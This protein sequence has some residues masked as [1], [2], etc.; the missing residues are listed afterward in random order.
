MHLHGSRHAAL[1]RGSD[2]GPAELA[3]ETGSGVLAELA[4]TCARRGLAIA[5]A[6]LGN[7]A[8]A[9]EAVQEAF[10]R[11]CEHIVDLRDRSRAHAWF[12][13]V[14]ATTC[15][16][17]LRRRKHGP[18]PFAWL[19]GDAGD[20]AAT[21]AEQAEASDADVG[22]AAADAVL[23]ARRQHAALV[24][25]L[26]R[27]ARQQRAALLLRYG[28]DLPVAEVARLLGVEPATVKVHLM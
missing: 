2:R 24:T 21:L 15:L 16:G 10:A 9:E 28:H 25:R 4:T 26:S 5:Y 17:V 13:R 6:M 19:S 14:V 8:E 12:F 3:G 7:R 20:A 11:A 23:A 27:L 22:V 1:A 18:I